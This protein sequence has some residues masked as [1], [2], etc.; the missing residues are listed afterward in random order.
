MDRDDILRMIGLE[1]RRT[2]GEYALPALGLFGVGI[3]VGAGLGLLFAPKS[4]REI[5]GDLT[6]RMHEIRERANAEKERLQ[7]EIQKD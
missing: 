7:Q 6:E 3:I 5:R 4:G 2:A 1:T